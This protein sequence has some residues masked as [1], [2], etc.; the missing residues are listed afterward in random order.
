MLFNNDVEIIWLGKD[1]NLT[2]NY[3]D[4]L[5]SETKERLMKFNN[6]VPL[7]KTLLKSN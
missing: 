1:K 2:G 6:L 7:P 5:N 4:H 3:F